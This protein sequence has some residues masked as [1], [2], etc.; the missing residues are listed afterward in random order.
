MK[1]SLRRCAFLCV[2]AFMS[3][4]TNYSA[5]PATVA[6]TDDPD[7][8]ALLQAAQRVIA[9]YHEGHRGSHDVLR[10]VYFHPHDRDPLPNY[11]ERLDRV[12]AD[13]SNFYRDGLQRFGIESTGI[14]LERKDGQ[15]VLHVVRG[16][17]P[18]KKYTRDS[19]RD[20]EAELRDAL[21]G[22]IDF[23]RER[24]LVLHGLGRREPDGRYIFDSPYYGL[25]SSDQRWGL[26]HALDCELLDP[27]LLTETKAKIVHNEHTDPRMEQTL[28]A[29][30]TFY[31]GGIAHELGHGLG[32]DHDAGNVAEAGNGDSLMGAGNLSYR[33]NLWDGGPPAFVSR[34][35]ALQLI[36]HPLLTGSNQ[37]RWEETGEKIER[38]DFSSVGSA[39]Q[40]E[41][42]VSSAIPAYAAVA[43]AWPRNGDEHFACTFPALFDGERF[44]LQAVRLHPQRYQLRL[45]F[46]YVNGA[47]STRNF[48]LNFEPSGA[49]DAIALNTAWFLSRAETAVAR[50]APEARNLLAT[51]TE[52]LD[53]TAEGQR[54]L[55]VLRDAIDPAE[56]I[57]LAAAEGSRAYLSDA[58]WIEAK[59]GWG[60]PARN[61]YWFDDQIQN[62]LFLALDGNFFDEA[63]YA[64]SPSHYGFS[65]DGR[66]QR[67]TAT[68]GLRDGADSQQGSA[69]FSVR[70]DGHVLY[71]SPKLKVGSVQQVS[72]D[73]RGVK[74]LELIAEGGEG[75][76][77]FSWA[78][79]ADPV[80]ER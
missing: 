53:L 9:A 7:G 33:Q 23:D 71:R 54:K 43:Y 26:C 8:C 12:L 48:D 17:Y 42:R 68:I 45:V 72:V 66:W 41:G 47:R 79:W 49:P 62:G 38:L 70:A 1:G 10:V 5:P 20:I 50:H 37:G 22:T 16:K 6:A 74:K 34:V 13:I 21:G 77:H 32:L 75:H 46:L 15:L 36:S 63:L 35:S 52:N 57:D 61:H 44:T 56:T 78:I 2:A 24:V 14:P 28:G 18:E 58:K 40:I 51:G 4:G 67:F 31:I 64:H 39:L 55:R 60:Q 11:V 27:R 19:G 76:N 29:F 3:V 80:V 30:N 25:S 65:L 69:V 59:V 73:V